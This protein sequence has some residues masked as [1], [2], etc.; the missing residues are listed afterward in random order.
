MLYNKYPV[1]TIRIKVRATATTSLAVSAPRFPTP[2]LIQGGAFLHHLQNLVLSL[3]FG[4]WWATRGLNFCQPLSPDSLTLLQ[5]T[6]QI[7]HVIERVRSARFAPPFA[8]A[9]QPTYTTFS[10][11]LSP[12]IIS[13][14]LRECNRQPA[15]NGLATESRFVEAARRMPQGLSQR[16]RQECS[17]AGGNRKLLYMRSKVYRERGRPL[18]DLGTIWLII[19]SCSFV[20]T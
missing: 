16:L 5:D 11:L 4:H 7:P 8:R 14:Q 20:T 2:E 19:E 3:P 18:Q 12:L 1:G 6:A 10:S 13:L 9:H 15:Q 17:E